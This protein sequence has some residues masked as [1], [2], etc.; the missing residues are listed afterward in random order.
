VQALLNGEPIRVEHPIAGNRMRMKG[1]V[2]LKPDWEWMDRLPTRDRVICWLTGGWLLLTYRYSFSGSRSAK[3]QAP[4]VTVPR[5]TST[6]ATLWQVL[7]GHPVP[8]IKP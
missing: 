2:T 4:I 8:S 6:L 3:S 7:V 5:R 1:N